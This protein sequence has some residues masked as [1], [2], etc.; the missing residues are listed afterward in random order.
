M[1][2]TVLATLA[3]FFLPGLGYLILAHRIPLAILWLIGVLGLT[4]VELSLK[5]LDSG[6]YW[7]MFGNVFLMN[8]AFAVDAF[9][10]GRRKMKGEACC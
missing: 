2:R 1:V 4:H 7:C 9:L 3:N 6:L 5:G 8:T 10:V